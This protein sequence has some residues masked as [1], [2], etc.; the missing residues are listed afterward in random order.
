MDELKWLQNALPPQPPPAI[1]VANDVMRT[2]RQKQP[3]ESESI[4]PLRLLLG[5]ALA[6][7]AVAG[8][9]VW[10]A[11]QAISTWQDPLGD[12]LRF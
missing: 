3:A 12:L 11:M 6:S 10:I 8:A 2:I 5:A 4:F 9:A 1:D 7:W